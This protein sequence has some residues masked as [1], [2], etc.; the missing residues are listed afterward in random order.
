[1]DILMFWLQVVG[2]APIAWRVLTRDTPAVTIGDELSSSH[3][4]VGLF[5]HEAGLLLVWCGFG[6]RF[7]TVGVE[8]GVTWQ[9][10]AGNT[11]LVLAAA[12][13]FGSL[14]VFKSWRLLAVVD[15]NHE[16]CTSGVYGIVRHPIY[17]AFNLTGIGVA[18]AVPSPIVIAGALM[19]LI[20]CEVRSRTE[21]K[22]L[23]A[24]FGDRYRAYMRRVSRV[25]PFVYCGQG[26]QAAWSPR[27]RARSEVELRADLE[28]A[29]RHHRRRVD[30]ADT[31]RSC[32][33]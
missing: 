23:L 26:D 7:W 5:L 20:A 22:V 15:A 33:R 6:L 24:A 10:V 31:P 14:A 2:F 18:L 4:H 1:M 28:E 29:C 25:I 16:L 27:R 17:V 32:S 21:E 12:L 30:S 11:L 3:R 13:T 19:L 9:G 8:R